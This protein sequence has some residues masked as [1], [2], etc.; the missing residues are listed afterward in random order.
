M[1]S[2]LYVVFHTFPVLAAKHLF[3]YIFVFSLYHLFFNLALR[4]TITRLFCDLI[5]AGLLPATEFKGGRTL[6]CKQEHNCC[7]CTL[8]LQTCCDNPAA[9]C[10]VCWIEDEMFVQEK[11]LQFQLVNLSYSSMIRV[12]V[13]WLHWLWVRPLINLYVFTKPVNL[14]CQLGSP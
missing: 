8:K 4:E 10:T 12:Y 11:L 3:Q 5:W 1:L 2:C 13:Y 6:S 9:L 14:I 7:I